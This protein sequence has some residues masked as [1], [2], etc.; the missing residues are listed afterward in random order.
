VG[1][2]GFF[3]ALCSFFKII[4]LEILLNNVGLSISIYVEHPAEEVVVIGHVWVISFQGELFPFCALFVAVVC[5][6]SF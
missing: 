3:L 4:E 1:I 5:L 6:L 2:G